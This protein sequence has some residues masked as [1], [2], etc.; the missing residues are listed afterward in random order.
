MPAIEHWLEEHV[1][2]RLLTHADGAAVRAL[3][4]GAIRDPAWPTG[5]ADMADALYPRPT[6]TGVDEGDFSR[7]TPAPYLVLR[8]NAISN[9]DDVRN[10][11]WQFYIYDDPGYL[12][13]FVREVEIALRRLYHEWFIPS[14]APGYDQWI[15]SDWT[16][17]S[18]EGVDEELN[19][20][21]MIVR[22]S[23]HG[24]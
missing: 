15:R 3:F 4:A 12:Y 10:S 20:H 14:S 19:K 21:R 17:S 11:G 22:F 24:G 16:S 7:D 8:M 18:N 2:T 1:K 9:P 23:C 5:I 6:E 13:E